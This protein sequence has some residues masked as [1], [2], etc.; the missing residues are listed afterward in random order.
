MLE[1]KKIK[2]IVGAIPC[3]CPLL[4]NYIVAAYLII[5]GIVGIFGLH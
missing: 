4:L 2:P 1:F 5:V 3:G